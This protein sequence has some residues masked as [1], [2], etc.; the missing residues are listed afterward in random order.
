MCGESAS[1]RNFLSNA[2][3]TNLESVDCGAP[4]SAS[5]A[6][7]QGEGGP[8]TAG[9]PSPA[10]DEA[11]SVTRLAPFTNQVDW[12]PL[13]C[14]IDSLDVGLDVSWGS[15]WGRL[16]SL[17][18]D[19]K[20]KASGTDGVLSADGR[21]L[22]LPS[23]K[24]PNYRWHLQWP[25]FHLFI[26]R[27]QH[28]QRSTP[29]VYASINAKALWT[30]T[31]L[32]A[33]E[34]VVEE[35]RHLDDQC[36]ISRI[37]PS[38]C[39][40][41]ADFLLPASLPLETLLAYRVPRHV[42]HSHNMTGEALETFYQGAKSSP[43]QLRIYHKSLEVAQGGTKYWLYDIWKV[44]PGSN[45]WRV[46]FQLRRP[47]LNELG[48]NSVDELLAQ[49]GGIWRY[50]TSDWFSLRLSDDSNVT[51]RTVLPAWATVQGCAE[52]FG[53][54]TEIERK[55]PDGLASVDWYISHIAGCLVGFGARQRLAEFE[56]AVS[57]LIEHLRKYWGS[58][59]YSTQYS[60]K[61]IQLGLTACPVS[62]ADLELP[63][64][65]DVYG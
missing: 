45:V 59:D 1:Q 47:F 3:Q 14:G 33:V 17:L 32:C 49:A 57:A 25:D 12:K 2:S 21:F 48:V 51:R 42:K 38:R 64:E 39:D 23:G 63:N 6:F 19:A 58:R 22:I 30:S 41:A 4:L 46:E 44:K 62:I 18:D 60:V 37:K 26:G 50:L 7:A 35:L 11:L 34:S 24:P 36:E 16:F 61:S 40:L 29:N 55:V 20:E 13:A 10:A 27:S 9:C 65:M 53:P 15:H 43:I 8:A 28:P 31:V 56:S 54:A 52:K 5:L